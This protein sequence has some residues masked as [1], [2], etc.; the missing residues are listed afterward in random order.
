MVTSAN[1][2]QRFDH[3]KVKHI[4]RHGSDHASIGIILEADVEEPIKK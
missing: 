1:F 2:I 3:V 4:S